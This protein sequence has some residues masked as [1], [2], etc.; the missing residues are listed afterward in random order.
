MYRSF[1]YFHGDV[2]EARI[3]GAI[4]PRVEPAKWESAL[5]NPVVINQRNQARDD[6]YVNDQLGYTQ[7]GLMEPED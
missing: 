2:I 1:D 6:L 7:R 3:A 4:K 5:R